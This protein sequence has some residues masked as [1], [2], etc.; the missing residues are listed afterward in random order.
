[1]FQPLTASKS[2]STFCLKNRRFTLFKESVDLP[3]L[4]QLRLPSHQNFKIADDYES[5]PECIALEHNQ[6]MK[7]LKESIH[8]FVNG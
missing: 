7:D 4:Q 5:D 1:L 6:I 8:K 2:S 3:W